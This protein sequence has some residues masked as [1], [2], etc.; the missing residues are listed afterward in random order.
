MPTTGPVPFGYPLAWGTFGRAC[1]WTPR[2]TCAS[3][4]EVCLSAMVPGASALPDASAV[5]PDPFRVCVAHEGDVECPGFAPYTKRH[6]LYEGIDDSRGCSPCTC[7]A[8]TGSTCSALVTIY[9]DAACSVQLG[10]ATATSS[11][12]ACTDVLPGAA[13]AS[14]S[15]G[16]VSY[17]PGSCTPS[18]GTPVG[19]AVPT[20]PVT[21]CCLP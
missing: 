4:G 15:A 11:A 20:M 19:D 1:T 21:F 5:V 12:P 10:S 18:G 2:G 3:P 16:S 14:K 7:G 17:T 8:P 9:S 13:L 6:L